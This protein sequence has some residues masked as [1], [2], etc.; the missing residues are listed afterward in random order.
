MLPSMTFD[1]ATLRGTISQRAVLD[2]AL[3]ELV[4]IVPSSEGSEDFEIQAQMNPINIDGTT[5]SEKTTQIEFPVAEKADPESLKRDYEL[6]R[7]L[8][9]RK[10]FYLERAACQIKFWVIC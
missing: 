6:L 5:Y 4:T 8:Y 10:F 1:D 3:L 7:I 2:Q 9:E